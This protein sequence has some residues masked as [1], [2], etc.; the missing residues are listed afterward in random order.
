[1]ARSPIP[2]PPASWLAA[3]VSGQ[4]AS[5]RGV[6]GRLIGRVWVTETAAVNDSALDLLEPQPHEHVL[7]IGFGPGRAIRRLSARAAEVTGVEVSDAMLAAAHRRNS[8]AI[9]RGRVRLLRG[10]GTT[11]RLAD[12]SVDAALAVHTPI[13]SAGTKVPP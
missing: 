4:A 5:P 6:L 12:D 13:P 9:R 1:V 7:E 3:V 11:L 8:A 2:G 10:D